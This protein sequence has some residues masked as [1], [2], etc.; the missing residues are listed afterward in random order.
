MLSSSPPH[1]SPLARRNIK[2]K[3]PR[4][5][6]PRHSSPLSPLSSPTND[7]Q[8]RRKRQYKSQSSS[9]SLPKLNIGDDTPQKQFLRERFKARCLERAKESRAR[10]VRKY[11]GDSSDVGSDGFDIE[12]DLAMEEEDGYGDVFDDE[13]YKRVMLNEIRRSQHA[14]RVSF[15]R[16]FGSSIDPDMYEDM[17]TLELDLTGQSSNVRAP[18]PPL[19]LDDYDLIQEYLAEL[20]EPEWEAM[21]ERISNDVNNVID[22]DGEDPKELEREFT[23]D[24]EHP[25]PSR[26]MY[27]SFTMSS[28][29]SS[30]SQR[31]FPAS[32]T[33]S[34]AHI[35]RP[36]ESSP[37]S[38]TRRHLP[39]LT[40]NI[41]SRRHGAALRQ[42]SCA[43]LVVSDDE[44][45]PR[46]P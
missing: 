19:D 28:P 32:T 40:G 30:P 44:L 17:E 22:I 27:S 6:Q 38:V 4:M 23:A 9:Y 34:T 16:D 14:K 37:Q 1:S 7:V 2:P 20:G 3:P 31:N 43:A 13:I 35:S 29:P 25:S 46:L 42:R 21:Q 41:T 39:P 12:G 10:A 45:A 33:V 8:N 18:S 15:E 11:R 36:W 5:Y 24:P 26:S